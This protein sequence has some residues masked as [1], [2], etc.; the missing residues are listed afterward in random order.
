MAFLRLTDIVKPVGAFPEVHGLDPEHN[1]LSAATPDQAASLEKL[2]KPPAEAAS[3]GGALSQAHSL[4]DAPSNAWT[5]SPGDALG[6]YRVERTLGRG[7]MGEVYLAENVLTNVRCALK[8]LPPSLSEAPTFRGRFAR[9]AAVLQGLRHD[10]IVMVHHAGEESGRFFLTMD[11]VDGGSLDD[12]LKEKGGLAEDET[13]RIAL[14]LCDALSYAHEKGVI[15]RDIKPANVLLDSDGRAKLS[16]FGLARVVGD[17]FLQ[18]MTER[19][20]SLSAQ[21]TGAG[22]LSQS[23]NAVIGTYEY[24][25]PEQKAGKPAAERSDIYSLGLVVYRMLTGEKAEGMFDLPSDLGCAECWDGIVRK[26]LA[27]KPE[28]RYANAKEL[29]ADLADLE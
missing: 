20:I 24:M 12:L 15:H 6:G 8:L 16:D 18:S 23:D 28:K 22:A 11:Y 25:S 19:S 4:G 29:L 13:A 5:L 27:P 10:G 7:G 9:E 17:E 2:C 21:R 26:T 1:G 14:D 3:D